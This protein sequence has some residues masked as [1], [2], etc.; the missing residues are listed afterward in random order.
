MSHRHRRNKIKLEHSV[1]P[2]LLPVLERIAAHRAIQAITPGRISRRAGNQTNGISFQYRTETGFKL[3]ARSNRAV[4]EI[5]VVTNRPDE[6]L[7]ALVA[8]GLVTAGDAAPSGAKGAQKK[9]SAPSGSPDASPASTPP[10]RPLRRRK[11]P[12]LQDALPG[13]LREK[14]LD[15]AAERPAQEPRGEVQTHGRKGRAEEGAAG[16][17]GSAPA[18]TPLWDEVLRR[19]RALL[20]LER[21]LLADSDEA[22]RP[23][24]SSA[25]R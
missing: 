3:L 7:A 14:M 16:P 6:A 18:G 17:T 11:S 25:T 12:S 9:R 21:S 19:H 4:Q 15:L 1:L 20:A 24:S 23:R 8:E 22:Q 2:G 10:P 13:E 5:F